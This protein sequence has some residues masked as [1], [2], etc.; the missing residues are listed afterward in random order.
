MLGRLITL[1]VI[2]VS[3][4][5]TTVAYPKQISKIPESLQNM[6]NIR[7]PIPG[8]LSAGPPTAEQ[9]AAFAS[10]GGE[11]VINLQSFEELK[12][13]PEASWA[14]T[15]NL[16]YFHIPIAGGDDLTRET[17]AQFDQIVTANEGRQ[18]LMHCGSGN[19]VGAM[20]ALRAAWHQGATAEEALAL[21]EEYGLASLKPRV[22]S[23]LK[24]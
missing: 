17:V 8:H 11:V 15:S 10:I 6:V 22:R 19:R 1:V 13:T 9:L 3:G 18:M 7:A 24:E 2:V 14:A 12:N 21:G 23:L 4:L 20:I 5:V 16:D